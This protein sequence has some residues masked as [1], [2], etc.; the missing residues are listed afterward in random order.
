MPIRLKLVIGFNVLLAALGLLGYFVFQDLSK[1]HDTSARLSSLQW[2]RIE[3]AGD[4]A[5]E[6]SQLRSLELQYITS[7][8]HEQIAGNLAATVSSIGR[9]MAEYWVGLENG[10]A[11]P[12]SFTREYTSYLSLHQKMIGLAD[13]GESEEALA[14]YADSAAAF[15]SLTEEADSVFQQALVDAR[16]ATDDQYSTL[17][18]ARYVLVGGLA[19]VAALV[20]GMGHPLSTYIHRRLQALIGAT[21]RVRRGDFGERLALSGGDEFQTVA[22]ALN[23][24]MDTLQKVRDE[25]VH[26]HAEALRT[27]EERIALLHKNITMVVKAQEDERLR[28]ARELHDQASQ[29][30]T[31]L[32]LGLSRL[33]QTVSSARLR[34]EISS[35]RGLTVE[36]MDMIRNVALDLR[37]STLDDLG[38]VPALRD[39][40]KTFSGRVGLPVEFEASGINGRLPAE[41]EI[42]LFR[43]AQEGL[44][45]VAKHAQASKAR[46]CLYA[47]SRR[48]LVL[49]VEDDGVGFDVDKAL[50][51]DSGKHLGLFGIQE[52]CLLLGA[53]LDLS[54][55]SGQGTRLVVSVPPPPS[56]DAGIGAAGASV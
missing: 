26:L 23:D 42:A 40:V 47:G 1:A 49:I 51:P 52:R 32:H 8:D 5:E 2:P 33:E 29:S 55:A 21:E 22:A 44:T 43:I 3:Q 35:L 17:G 50:G 46:V 31:G 9:Q 37:P 27:R 18:R 36:A 16:V 7:E 14:L 4:I 25:L 20:F 39:Y 10:G 53:R 48:P 13:A 12:S 30:L 6:I 24:M 41:T 11:P 38:L 28:V 54:S 19:A 15:G 45:N 34:E 56:A